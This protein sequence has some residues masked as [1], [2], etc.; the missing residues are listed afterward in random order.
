VSELYTESTKWAA[1]GAGSLNRSLGNCPCRGLIRH[2]NKRRALGFGSGMVKYMRGKVGHAQ[3]ICLHSRHSK[4]NKPRPK[5]RAYTELKGLVYV[6][7]PNNHAH[8]VV[9]RKAY[10]HFG[11]VGRVVLVKGIIGAVIQGFNNIERIEKVEHMGK[12]LYAK[13]IRLGGEHIAA[14]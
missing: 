8:V 13:R 7:K 2:R 1:L 12:Y 6:L 3:L 11:V 5:A 10:K 4:K 14:M 9:A